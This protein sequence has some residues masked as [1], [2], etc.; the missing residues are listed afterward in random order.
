M[1][2]Q[3]NLITPA[4]L[5]LPSQRTASSELSFSASPLTHLFLGMSFFFFFFFFGESDLDSVAKIEDCTH[6]IARSG[7]FS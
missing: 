3:L 7:F 1:I 6:M 4:S 5:P 2:T